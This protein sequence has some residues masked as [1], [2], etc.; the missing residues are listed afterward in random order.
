MFRLP[1]LQS[2]KFFEAAAR[3]GSFTEA[4]NEIGVSQGA[5]SQHI[6][7]L[8]IR[9]GFA[10]FSRQGRQI[11][12]TASGEELL[13]SVIN[14]LSS[15]QA[16]IELE[17]RKQHSNECI[18][19]VLP[20]FAI[21]WL[22]P[23]LMEFNACYPD[24][25]ININTVTQPLD[26]NLYHAHAA[27]AYMP[28]EGKFANATPL[29][30]EYMFPVCAKEF[31]RAHQLSLPLEN[32]NLSQLVDLPLLADTSPTAS[33][34]Q[35]T[36]NYWFEQQGMDEL[37]THCQFNRQSQSNI[38]LQLA[39]LGHGIAI[40]RTSLIIDALNKEVLTPVSKHK[41]KNP[42]RY[43]VTRNPAIATSHSLQVFEQWL[44]KVCEEIT[45]YQL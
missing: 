13:R 11:E 45:E 34:Y 1:S 39:E 35:N 5:V 16:T 18:I 7:N 4:A 41:V 8:E 24:I 37:S 15:I 10:V 28:L 30:D 17:R 25:R 3:L 2:L 43:F 23:R 31:A 42:Y 33:S 29:F 21:R 26:F 14:N 19:S 32:D 6:K 44:F 36:W 27:I 12:L 40:G 9:V 22:F 38:T 20:G